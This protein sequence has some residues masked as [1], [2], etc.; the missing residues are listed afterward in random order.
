MQEPKPHSVEKETDLKTFMYYRH[1]ITKTTMGILFL[2]YLLPCAYKA[3]HIEVK[4]FVKCKWKKP[5]KRWTCFDRKD[6]LLFISPSPKRANSE[7]AHM[8][9]KSIYT[10][11]ESDA[12]FFSRSWT[13]NSS[14]CSRYS[15]GVKFTTVHNAVQSLEIFMSYTDH[16]GSSAQGVFCSMSHL[17]LSSLDKH[18]GKK[19]A[20]VHHALC[21]NACL[22]VFL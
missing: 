4:W 19:Q 1:M 11:S 16:M 3:L 15:E 18:W 5:N 14:Y 22:V 12:M 17:N 20:S 10:W 6:F 9:C 13:I 8:D 2:L 21:Q 7:L